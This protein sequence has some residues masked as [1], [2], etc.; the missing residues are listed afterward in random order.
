[1]VP[2]VERL[3]SDEGGINMKEK[4]NLSSIKPV[5]SWN[6]SVYTLGSLIPLSFSHIR[7]ANPLSPG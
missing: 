3:K 7:R 6:T 2:L 5:L 1:M 4:M